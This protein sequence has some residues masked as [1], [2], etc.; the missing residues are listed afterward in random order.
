[1]IVN[2]VFG[3]VKSIESNI[4]VERSGRLC[5]WKYLGEDFFRVVSR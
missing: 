1:M 4:S 2:A 3:N 5:R